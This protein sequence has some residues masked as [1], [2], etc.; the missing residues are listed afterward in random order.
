MKQ[1]R[2]WR[3]CET[4]S[5]KE[6]G[7]RFEGEK[8]KRSCGVTFNQTTCEM[9]VRDFIG[10]GKER[11]QHSFEC[12]RNLPFLL[13]WHPTARGAVLKG[14]DDALLRWH[15]KVTR[16]AHILVSWLW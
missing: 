14:P 2:G 6:N 3:G 10:C 13:L 4:Q 9:S 5:P 1:K 15:L 12:V 16:V 8:K 11:R 7:L